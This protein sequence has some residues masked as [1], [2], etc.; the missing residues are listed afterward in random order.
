VSPPAVTLE[1]GADYATRVVRLDRAPVQGE[2]SYRLLVDE[3]PEPDRA[4]NGAVAL[5]VRY[6]IPVFFTAADARA[7]HLGWS[8]ERKDGRVSLVARNDGTRRLRLSDLSVSDG[9]GHR[10]SFGPGLAGYV[11]GGSAMRFTPRAKGGFSGSDLSVSAMTD[12]GPIHGT[13][14]QR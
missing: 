14:G 10:V 12:L 13:V 7:P 4:R 11:L 3:L 9:A 6:S 1:P 2:L 5:V 8:V